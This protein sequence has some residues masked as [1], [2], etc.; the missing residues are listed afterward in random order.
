M[1]IRK[2]LASVVVCLS[3]S[4]ATV[5]TTNAQT[6]T[7][8]GR[9]IETT[10]YILESGS[11]GK[12]IPP[13][14][15]S[16]ARSIRSDLKVSDLKLASVYFGRTNDKGFFSY[17]GVADPAFTAGQTPEMNQYEKWTIVFAGSA[18]G[19]AVELSQFSY[20][21]TIPVKEFGTPAFKELK[22]NSG[23]VSLMPDRPTLMGSLIFPGKD[24]MQFVVL[25]L[26]TP[27]N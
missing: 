17:N 9:T 2:I 14:L 6:P 12:Q 7:D 3:I 18:A 15:E 26:R 20:S 1:N 25:R 24:R 23:K 11:G 21:V 27:I 10:V 22:A 5:L 19:G 4:A 8:I 16:V 13:E